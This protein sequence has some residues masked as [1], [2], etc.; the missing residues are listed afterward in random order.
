[1]CRV[2]AP[3]NPW[4]LF[5]FGLNLCLSDGKKDLEDALPLHVGISK[6]RE[7]NLPGVQSCLERYDITSPKRAHVPVL[8]PPTFLSPTRVQL[9]LQA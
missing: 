6:K 9:V 1:M 5:R 8:F 4:E 7:S 3:I 2:E